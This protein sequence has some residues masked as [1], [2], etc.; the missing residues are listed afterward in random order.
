[1]TTL[2]IGPHHVRVKT[3]APCHA[4][5]ADVLPSQMTNLK[6][7]TSINSLLKLWTFVSM[8][9][10]KKINYSSQSQMYAHRSLA[11]LFEKFVGE[12]THYIHWIITM[13]TLSQN[14]VKYWPGTNYLVSAGCLFQRMIATYK[15]LNSDRCG[16]QFGMTWETRSKQQLALVGMNELNEFIGCC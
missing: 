5:I 7:N 11:L 9:S 10:M 8:E 4:Y 12:L 6:Y 3:K 15:T 2:V 1:M 16:L 14:T 13:D